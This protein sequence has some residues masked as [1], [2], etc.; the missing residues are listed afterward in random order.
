MAQNGASGARYG[1]GSTHACASKSPGDRTGWRR[2]KTADAVDHGS[3]ETGGSVRWDGPLDRLRLVELGQC[4]DAADRGV[5]AVQVAFTRQA[6]L[7]DL[8][9]VDDA[10]QLRHARAGAAA[11]GTEVVPGQCWRDLPVDELDPR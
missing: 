11:T 7:L 3:S 1:L 10:R 5:D 6:H 2:R 4:G 8:A 9:H